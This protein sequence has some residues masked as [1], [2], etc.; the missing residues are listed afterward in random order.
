[1]KTLKDI[2]TEGILADNVIKEGILSD[3][4][5]TLQAGERDAAVMLIKDFIEKN[6]HIQKKAVMRIWEQPNE[7]G[8]YFVDVEGGFVRVRNRKL[9]HLTNDL[10]EWHHIGGEFNCWNCRDL[11]DLVG[12]PSNVDDCLNVNNC[13]SLKSLKGAPEYVGEGGV[14]CIECYSL[15]TL[16]GAPKTVLGDFHCDDCPNLKSLKGAPEVLCSDFWCNR[17]KKL[18]SL[19]GLPDSIGR[20]LYC[21]ACTGL[22]TIKGLPTKIGGNLYLNIKNISEDE[23]R[24]IKGAGIKG[25]I[26]VD[27]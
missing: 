21:Q 24:N 25:D 1:M 2:L 23:L 5:D 27:K 18:T 8:K 11:I 12:G 16:E 10:F 19:E 26:I 3:M 20:S 15:E 6:Y 9:T 7:D 14:C 22:N 13:R 17:C 4:E